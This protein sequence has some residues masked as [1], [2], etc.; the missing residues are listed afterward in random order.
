MK[1]KRDVVLTRNTLLHFGLVR[2]EE[3]D[4][5]QIL[6]Q[7]EDLVE[8]IELVYAEQAGK[9]YARRGRA[10]L[11]A[12]EVLYL[13]DYFDAVRRVFF[14]S[15]RHG[16]NLALGRSE[17]LKFILEFGSAS[18]ALC[19]SAERNVV[20]S[21]WLAFRAGEGTVS[22]RLND[23]EIA[24]CLFVYAESLDSRGNQIY[25]FFPASWWKAH[26]GSFDT[27]SSASGGID[28]PRSERTLH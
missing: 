23:R 21:H 26:K 18:W 25:R 7:D 15:S 6:C 4:L 27:A 9:P 20:V 2:D 16:S 19:N 22:G 24:E 12:E 10:I 5:V 8:Y 17:A 14:V 3:K 1:A 28:Y 13:S 11:T